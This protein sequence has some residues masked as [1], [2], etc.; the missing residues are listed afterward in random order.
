MHFETT[1][2]MAVFGLIIGAATVAGAARKLRISPPILLVLVGLAVSYLPGIPDYTL[3]PEII[4]A[5]F[6]P[7]LLYSAAWRSSSRGFRLNKR[8]ILLMSVGYTL[9]STVLVALVAYWL[10]PSMPLAAAFALGAIIAPPDAVAATAVGRELGMQRRYLQ[11]LQGESLVNDATALTAYRAAVAAAAG[12]ITL[13]EGGGI[14]VAA[15]GGG[16]VLGG[17]FGFLLREVRRRVTSAVLEN[18]LNLVVPFAVYLAAESVHAS[19]VLAVVITGLYLGNTATDTSPQAR[20]QAES[21]W[22]VIDFVLE[23]IVFALIGLQLPAV[24]AELEG[25]NVASVA[26]WSLAVLLVTIAGR[27]IWVFSSSYLIR[28]FSPAV[29]ARTPSPYWPTPTVSSWAG[30]RGVVSLAAAFALAHDFPARGLILWLTFVVVFGTLVI[31]GLTLPG[32]IRRLGVGGTDDMS[33]RLAEANAQ[34]QAARAATE[35]LDSLVSSAP[36]P[37]S[38]QVVGLLRHYSEYRA[39]SAWERLGGGLSHG[40]KETPG[41]AFRR[42]RQEMLQAQRET[43][44]RLRQVGELDDEVMREMV[45]ELDLEETM[46]DRHGEDPEPK[47]HKPPVTSG[48]SSGSSGGSSGSSGDSEAPAEGAGGGAAGDRRGVADPT[49]SPAAA[50]DGTNPE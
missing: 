42:L 49:A 24:I 41:A 12:G 13:L 30:M 28:F 39:N 32:L 26:W 44:M 9:F 23:S 2:L 17:L 38:D 45:R 19:G 14:F 40:G 8:P 50:A 37:P 5:L 47:G 10:I 27:F 46:L 33:D 6:L 43:F 36:H 3:N 20:L 48:D 4:L 18:T 25:Q 16:V 35:R 15:A 29:R 34:H 21:S 7:P 22:E 11:V 1:D 31:Q